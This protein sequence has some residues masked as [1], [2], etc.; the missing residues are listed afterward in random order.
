MGPIQR[1]RYHLNITWDAAVC[2]RLYFYTT[3][4]IAELQ[5]VSG[6]VTIGARDSPEDTERSAGARVRR[7]RSEPRAPRP[8]HYAPLHSLHMAPRDNTSGRSSGPR[9]DPLTPHAARI[10]DDND[11]RLQDIT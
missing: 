11:N 9:L 2:R 1:P 4:I 3:E 5:R 10:P 7:R 6:D 8:V